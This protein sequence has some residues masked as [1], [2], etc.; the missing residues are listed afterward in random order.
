MGRLHNWIEDPSDPTDLRMDITYGPMTLFDVDAM[1]RAIDAEVELNDRYY[2]DAWW[3]TM[4]LEGTTIAMRTGDYVIQYMGWENPQAP[5]KYEQ[6][7]CVGQYQEWDGTFDGDVY[8]YSYGSTLITNDEVE[9][10]GDSI[11][12]QTTYHSNYE[13]NGPWTM[14]ASKKY[15]NTLYRLSRDVTALS[16][17]GVRRVRSD[18]AYFNINEGEMV[19]MR[20][21]FR[22]YSDEND[23]VAR[24]FKD[25]PTMKFELKGASQLYASAVAFAALALT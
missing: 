10:N 23:Q 18:D 8:N 22:I 15:Y 6:W 16:C 4:I 20:T 17:T 25:Y 3:F 1:Q 2:S 9:A 11:D 24:H 5:G 7:S 13:R 21:G 19:D 12:Y 14:A